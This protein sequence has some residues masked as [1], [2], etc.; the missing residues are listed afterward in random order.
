[1]HSDYIEVKSSVE[2]RQLQQTKGETDSFIRTWSCTHD[3]SSF[4]ILFIVRSYL[5]FL[6]KYSIEKLNH[7]KNL[8]VDFEKS[9]IRIFCCWIQHENKH[10]IDLHFG[11][12]VSYAFEWNHNGCRTKLG[13]TFFNIYE[14]FT[15]IPAK[16]NS[17]ECEYVV[18]N[19]EAS[20]LHFSSLLFFNF[21]HKYIPL[22]FLFNENPVDSTYQ[23][24]YHTGKERERHRGRKKKAK[25]P[26][27]WY[28]V[29]RLL[30][31]SLQIQFYTICRRDERTWL[32]LV[33]QRSFSSVFFDKDK[34]WERERERKKEQ[35]KEKKKNESYK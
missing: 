19:I 8:V 14:N 9:F 26:H 13:K 23:W 35:E 16:K 33:L 3:Q 10:S 34:A 12:M 24:D 31:Q 15:Q 4:P 5:K 17:E 22:L 25:I 18:A 21:L 11:L 2:W 30:L 7:H 32:V 27:I 29:L 6:I 28:I 1:M 20:G